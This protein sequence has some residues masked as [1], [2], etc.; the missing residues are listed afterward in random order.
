LLSGINHSMQQSVINHSTQ[1]R[2]AINQHT[3]ARQVIPA[4]RLTK[5]CSSDVSAALDCQ[6]WAVRLLHHSMLLSVI[7]HSIQHQ[8]D[9]SPRQVCSSDVLVLVRQRAVQQ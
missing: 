2:A 7:N 3:L 5:L 1:Q 4:Q 9:A 6:W 8:C